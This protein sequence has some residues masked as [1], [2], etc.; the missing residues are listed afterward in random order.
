MDPNDLGP[1]ADPRASAA[2]EGATMAGVGGDAA[3]TLLAAVLSELPDV[4]LMFQVSPQG[5]LLCQ[6]AMSSRPTAPI[7]QDLVGKGIE[8]IL[9]RGA[10]THFG[11]RYDEAFTSKE[12]VR[13]EEDMAVGDARL[14]LE[15]TLTPMFNEAGACTH[16]FWS[17]RDLTEHRST[18]AALRESEERFNTLIDS[19]SVGIAWTDPDGGLVQVNPA[20][21][22]LLGKPVDRLL[23][24]TIQELAHPEDA[25]SVT[26]LMGDALEGHG[27]TTQTE[28]RLLHERGDPLWIKGD[29]ALVRDRAGEPQR[30]IWQLQD[31]TERRGLQE[32]LTHQSLH[33]P[34]SG[35]PNRA[36]FIDRLGRAL[37]R[38]DRN[39][40]LVAVMLLDLD[41]FD[42]INEA[43]G[44]EI[45]DRYLREL[46]E[47]LEERVRAA[48]TVARLS[49]D[50]FAFV[51]EDLQTEEDAHAVTDRI[52]DAVEDPLTVEANDLSLTASIGV[53]LTTSAT[54]RP[55]SMLRDAGAAMHRAKA[56]GR[57]R[58]VIFDESMRAETAKRLKT[59]SDLQRAIEEG[60]FR[61]FYQPMIDLGTGRIV[62]VEVLA[63]WQHPDRGLVTPGEFIELAEETGLIVPLGRWVLEQACLQSQRW[64]KVR[65]E[66][67][68]TTINISPRQ[69]LESDLPKTIEK[70][71]AETGA[72]PSSLCLE[73][74]EGLLVEESSGAIGT[75][76]ELK[77]LGLQ[78]GIDDFGKGFSSLA[79]LKR[80]P[81][82]MLKL[83]RTFVSGIGTSEEDQAIASAV[84]NLARAMGLT[85][86][87]EG[88]ETAEQLA[89]L[90]E[91][92]CDQ[93]QGYFFSSPQPPEVL[94]EL[95]SQDLRW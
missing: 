80:L 41:R 94:M 18:M 14:H 58:T 77:D 22:E 51:V 46:G 16:L 91:L 45:G 19:S 33:D 42:T 59:E 93:G 64:S 37:S 34:L 69:L 62:G 78:I 27:E 4:I 87:A 71:L 48:D 26:R 29:V 66:P 92:G 53:A 84:V 35:L 39:P 76:R 95:L 73:I 25:D 54:D 10:L 90:R 55:E 83:D 9:P 43:H 2:V 67:M 24:T 52:R 88:V 36:L 8:Q 3:G 85:S 89:A 40:G 86:I 75:L 7:L 12:P 47:R 60:E 81:V 28:I 38:L 13:Y 68:L 17:A 1:E 44:H 15:A 31:M 20:L 63:R 49:S 82:D 11:E 70:V 79:Y 72:E 21:S 32:R 23:S 6:S 50:E 74:T 56:D 5:R 57:S 30:F 61:L 65:S